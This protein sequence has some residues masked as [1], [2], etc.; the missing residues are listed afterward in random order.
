MVVAGM[1]AA[2]RHGPEVILPGVAKV[3]P[4]QRGRPGGVTLRKRRHFLNFGKKYFAI[5]TA[6]QDKK[7]FAGYLECQNANECKSYKSTINKL[8]Y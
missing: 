6:L 4:L 7:Y 1:A 2:G 8:Y 5:P 3:A